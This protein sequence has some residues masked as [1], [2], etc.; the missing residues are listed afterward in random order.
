M[1]NQEIL[2]GL[3]AAVARGEKIEQAKMTFSNAGYP[4]NEIE[5]AISELQVP[6][7]TAP[8]DKKN[9]DQKI[10]DYETQK[11]K[12]LNPKPAQVE[13]KISKYGDE[14]NPKKKNIMIIFLISILTLLLGGLASMFVFK[15]QMMVLLEKIFD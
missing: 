8:V 5:E 11:E 10:S 3:K 14:K 15:D 4:V 9:S 2:E 1:V 13:Q 6:S 12:P 7:Q